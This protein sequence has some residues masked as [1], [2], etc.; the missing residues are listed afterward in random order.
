MPQRD[1]DRTPLRRRVLAALLTVGFGVLALRLWQLQILQGE[2]YEQLAQSNRLRL[3]R[4]PAPR[5]LILDRRG[6]VLVTNR[7]SFSVSVLSMALRD[8]PR[9][10]R[11][12]SQLL[13]LPEE[14][15]WKK[16]RGAPP[17]E[18]IRLQRDVGMGVVSAVEERRSDLRGVTIVAEP[19][20]LYPDRTLMSH[21]LGY[22]GEISA[23]EL[24]VLRP[25]GYRLGDLIGKA[26]LER[27]YD[28][29]LRG[30]D[31]EQVV[32][33]DA[34]GRPLRVLRQ[35]EGR[36]GNTLVLTIDRRL[37][38]VAEQALGSQ[39]GAV[40]ALDPRTGEV[41]ALASW[42]T[43]D[44]NRFAVGISAPA[45]V[46]LASDPRHPLLN[47]AVAAAYEPGS[48]YKIATSLV[49][50]E[51]GAASRHSAFFCPGQ[52]SLGGR[53][54]RDLRAHGHITF[55]DGVAQSCNVMFWQLGL[56]VGPDRI[57]RMARMLGLGERTGIDLPGEAEGI[58]PSPT[59]KERTYK[60]PWY[61]GD[62]LNLAIGQG[63]ALAT[64]IQVARMVAAV[65][66]GGRVLRPYL[67]R[68][69]LDPE[70]HVLA[71]FGPQV[72]RRLEIPQE[73]WA[74][75]REGLAAVVARGTG[76]A[77]AV[78]GLP[79][80]GKTGSAETPRGRPH[81]WFAGYAPAP[82]PRIVVV[83]LIEHGGRGGLAAAPVARQVFEAWKRL[84][85]PD[86]LAIAHP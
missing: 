56:R 8:P 82:D 85:A 15:I 43:Y 27:S 65:A 71:R 25:R 50:L 53:I 12:L 16:I 73:A 1:E 81:A 72:V 36:P 31:G 19:V 10:V 38:E 11:V 63:Y 44:P 78:P 79:V 55:L 77:A 48:V 61:P 45:W 69:I 41:L 86:Q 39:P 60:E 35:Q 34:A 5:G 33:V 20:R 54:F 32:E 67:V 75:L 74:T 29:A 6:A 23:E 28:A 17:F 2:Y 47:R 58:V 59:Y 14:E 46:R 40:V 51:A 64:P 70:G 62:T 80:A 7:P 68:A 22:L 18:L 84:Y 24:S 37:Q 52:L 9:T 57:S 3:N 49:A 83:V 26:G 42:P 4:L 30:E 21:V 66:N 13:D 76:Q